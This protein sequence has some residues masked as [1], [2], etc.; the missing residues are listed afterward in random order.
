MRLRNTDA[1]DTI[2]N[3][4]KIGTNP[5]M[6][7]GTV[8]FAWMMGCITAIAIMTTCG[9]SAAQQT[10]PATT[11]ATVSTTPATPVPAASV[12]TFPED[13]FPGTTV[14]CVSISD[15]VTLEKQW[16]QTKASEFAADP[17]VQKFA[18]DFQR[19][20]E[21]RIGRLGAFAGITWSDFAKVSGG[22][23]AMG[24][25]PTAENI[26]TELVLINITGHVEEAR[27]LLERISANVQNRSGRISTLKINDNLPATCYVLPP[28]K[29]WKQPNPP[30]LYSAF[31]GTWLLVSDNTDSIYEVCY[32]IS[33]VKK[34]TLSAVENYRHTIA[35]LNDGAIPTGHIRF[36][37]DPQ[38]LASLPDPNAPRG[39]ISQKKSATEIF[40]EQGLS[41]MLGIAGQIDLGEA[42]SE[43]M[44]KIAVYAPPPRE[45][46]FAMLKLMDATELSIDAWVPKDAA[47]CITLRLD[48]ENA[49]DHFGPIFDAIAERRGAW[50]E[51][52]EGWRIDPHGSQLDMRS[53][54]VAFL[55]SR[56]TIASKYRLP[57]STSS[58][59]LI[60]SVETKDDAAITAGLK[61]F[62]KDSEMKEKTLGGFPTWERDPSAQTA[63][64]DMRSPSFALGS[65]RTTTRTTQS[66]SREFFPNRCFA[67]AGGRLWVASHLDILQEVLS[68]QINSGIITTNVP[69]TPTATDAAAGTRGG[70]AATVEAKLVDQLFQQLGG[71]QRGL[72]MTFRTDESIRNDYELMRQRKFRESQSFAGRIFASILPGLENPDDLDFDLSSAPEFGYLRR[73]LGP[74][75]LE[76]ETVPQGW[77]VRGFVLT[78]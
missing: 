33:G 43:S 7:K 51:A 73:F 66:E 75:G 46:A 72:R 27:T 14:A 60:M 58:Q 10:A 28:P 63:P 15:V 8:F 67:V 36:Y 23:V 44:W 31:Y 37:A 69:T 35:L 18:E 71:K 6:R 68:E 78:K 38:R 49:F 16:K 62:F 11:A 65:R 30:T 57:V 54:I 40:R 12:K 64:S 45:S 9:L 50:D 52:L 1:K 53:E 19:Q 5:K 42:S 41:G 3:G 4:N 29:N 77:V 61:K 70:F 32:R 2:M 20:L 25:I 76:I 13:F 59:R 39:E 47:D 56:I 26:P 24:T 22:G 74:G 21:Q 34:D 48:M 55:G 17:A